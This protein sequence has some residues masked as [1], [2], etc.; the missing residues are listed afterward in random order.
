LAGNDTIE[1]DVMRLRDGNWVLHHD[2]VT[3]R[4]SGRSDGKRALLSAATAQD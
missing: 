2:L 1:I 3:G 4:A